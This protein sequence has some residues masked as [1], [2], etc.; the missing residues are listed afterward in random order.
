LESLQKE[1]LF[2]QSSRRKLVLQRNVPNSLLTGQC[3]G[4]IVALTE[5]IEGLESS[6]QWEPPIMPE[7][8]CGVGDM[9]KSPS[10]QYGLK[11]REDID[12]RGIRVT[13]GPMR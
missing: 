2:T 4:D 10:S 5:R 11:A 8:D 12:P 9:L 3:Y 1:L 6:G 13:N 7:G